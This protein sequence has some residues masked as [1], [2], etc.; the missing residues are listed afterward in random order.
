MSRRPLTTREVAERISE[1]WGRPVSPATVRTWRHRGQGPPFEQP[2]G[3]GSQPTYFPE[4]VE[5]WAIRNR[6]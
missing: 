1:V 2:A 4:L 5:L 3:K 6:K